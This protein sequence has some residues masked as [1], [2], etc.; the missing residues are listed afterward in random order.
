L[1][2]QRITKDQTLLRAAVSMSLCIFMYGVCDVARADSISS[3]R[4]I[5]MS[6]PSDSPKDP[7]QS[8]VS[9]RSDR[10]PASEES[11]SFVQLEPVAPAIAAARR[12]EPAVR[13][14]GPE[15]SFTVVQMSL[16]A[17]AD[18]LS[19]ITGRAFTFEG[20]GKQ[21]IRN[22]RLV[23]PLHD[24]LEGLSTNGGGVIWYYNGIKY[25][26]VHSASSTNIFRTVPFGEMTE[27]QLMQRVDDAFPARTKSIV[28][29][30]PTSR[31][32]LV[33][34][35]RQFAEEVEKS[36]RATRAQNPTGLSVV[37]YGIV[38]K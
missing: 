3:P 11:S 33:R 10:Q 1:T 7:I 5:G 18:A 15:I 8:D 4:R 9:L 2:D 13:D 34:G 29:I 37:R 6:R 26:L 36:I 23:G 31:V 17:L 30:N 20:D 12:A 16:Q 27:V 21:V 19:K 25:T 38:G 22:V 32:L 35:P 14:P 28:D 24:A